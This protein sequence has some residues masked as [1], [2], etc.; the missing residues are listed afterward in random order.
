MYVYV[1]K[2]FC[3]IDF[4]RIVLLVQTHAIIKRILRWSSTIKEK[5]DAE[6]NRT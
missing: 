4:S 3:S 1:L 5:N 6:G 2:I